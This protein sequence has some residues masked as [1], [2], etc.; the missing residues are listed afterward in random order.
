M[1]HLMERRHNTQLLMQQVSY[2]NVCAAPQQDIIYEMAD[3]EA[4]LTCLDGLCCIASDAYVVY[5]PE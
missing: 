3:S 2:D 5:N 1:Q 4:C